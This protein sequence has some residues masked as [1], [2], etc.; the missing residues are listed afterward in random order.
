MSIKFQDSLEFYGELDCAQSS[1][2]QT[3]VTRMRTLEIVLY[4]NSSFAIITNIVD[5]IPRGNTPSMD[6][7]E[8]ASA[9]LHFLLCKANTPPIIEN[10]ASIIDNTNRTISIVITRG[11][12]KWSSSLN[13]TSKRYC[14]ALTA[15]MAM[16]N[17]ITPDAL[18]APEVM[19]RMPAAVG[20]H[21]FSTLVSIK[22]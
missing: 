3:C 1:F 20:F 21:V 12:T 22:S 11:A 2:V 5:A 8:P 16:I 6:M 4:L 18:S 17:A 13:A 7:I 10:T 14:Q 15:V 9:Q 19:F